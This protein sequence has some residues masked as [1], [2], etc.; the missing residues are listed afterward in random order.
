MTLIL[1]I[2]NLMQHFFRKRIL[3]QKVEISA[4]KKNTYTSK[5]SLKWIFKLFHGVSVLNVK[6]KSEMSSFIVNINQVRLRLLQ[7]L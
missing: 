4:Q 3:E 6:V 7:L 1:L 5:P 2:Y